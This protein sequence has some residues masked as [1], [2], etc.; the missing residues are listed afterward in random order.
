MGNMMIDKPDDTIDIIIHIDG[1]CV[2][3]SRHNPKKIPTAEK[4]L[5]TTLFHTCL[6]LGSRA[7]YYV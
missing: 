6:N 3:I 2:L 4:Y 5:L 7:T 1:L